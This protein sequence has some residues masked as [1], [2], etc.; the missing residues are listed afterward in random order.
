MEIQE[1]GDSLTVRVGDFGRV[2]SE[3]L[4]NESGSDIWSSGPALAQPPHLH[5][6]SAYCDLTLPM[7]VSTSPILGGLLLVVAGLFQL[8]PLKQACLTHCRTPIGFLMS[9]WRERPGGALVMGLRHG[10][11][12]TGCCWALMALLFVAGV[13][14]LLW[15]A[16]IALFVLVEK[17]VPA[18]H[19]VGRAAGL[20]LVGWGIWLLMGVYI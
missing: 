4:R 1:E 5:N 3:L 16:A 15:V 11:Y 12:C 6:G 13:M 9:E 14:N 18:G 2:K 19:W 8:T 17:S 7:M 20:M 10:L